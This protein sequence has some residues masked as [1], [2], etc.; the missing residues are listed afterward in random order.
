MDPLAQLFRIQEDGSIA[1]CGEIG[2]G[3]V[4]V[5]RGDRA[6]I[7]IDD[8]RLSREHFALARE[9]DI[10][11]VY[12]LNSRNGTWVGGRKISRMEL[13]SSGWIRA[14]RTRFL[15]DPESGRS[16]SRQCHPTELLA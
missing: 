8:A 1:P 4:V 14:G 12:D 5:G 9:G 13:K 15:F 6:D 16:L 10:C 2:E 7:R 3:P 11:V